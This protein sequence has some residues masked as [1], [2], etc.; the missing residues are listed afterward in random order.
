MQTVYKVVR[1]LN[2]KFYSAWM[3]GECKMHYRIGT[4]TKSK[5]GPLFAFQRLEDARYWY[6]NMFGN[7]EP[8]HIF[9][10]IAKISQIQP[11]CLEDTRCS[12]SEAESREFWKAAK[13][14]SGYP[15]EK[16]ARGTV[17]CDSIK[18]L[19]IA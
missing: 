1:Q 17:F 4:V 8:F 7:N 5:F 2:G 19:A 18:L 16:V 9:Q 14:G 15:I 3:H 11:K 12:M 6:M 10:A 13:I